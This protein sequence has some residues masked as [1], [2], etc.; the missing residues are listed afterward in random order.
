M[1]RLISRIA[2]FA[3]GAASLAPSACSPTSMQSQNPSRDSERET[4]AEESSLPRGEVKAF[5]TAEGFGA[6]T[7]GGRGGRICEVTNL[8]NSGSGSLRACA[9]ASG[10]RI[11]VFRTAGTITVR[12]DITIENPYLTVAGQTASGAGITLKSSAAHID[13][14]IAVKAH[15]VVIRHVRFRP[16]PSRRLSSMRRGIS[17]EAGAYN[18]ILDHVSVS[19]ATDENVT[20]IDGVHDVT[21]QWSIISEGLNNSTHVEGAHSMGMLISYQQFD[22]SMK[23]QDITVHHNL[24]AHNHDRNPR[25]ASWG[26]VDAVNNVVYDFGIRG[27]NVSDSSGVKVPQNVVANYFKAGPSTESYAYDV[28][29]SNDSVGAALYVEGNLG[30]HRINNNQPQSYIVDPA[31]RRYVVTTRHSAPEVATTSAS[32]A[33]DDVLAG[34]GTRVPVLDPVDRRIINDV[35][36]RTGRIIDDPS[37][38]G[39]WPILAAGT[40]LGDRDHDGMPDRWEVLHGLDPDN[41]LD[42]PAIAANGYTNVENYL[43]E[44]AGDF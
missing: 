28:Q 13:G 18:V 5:P 37:D 15:D 20:L 3:L 2:V 23:T 4:P 25:N 8:N 10:P 16:G 26:L 7:R 44:L 12:D 31:D 42:G 24:F 33:Y 39:G 41:R 21:V 30:P 43:N 14:P 32:R 17:L 29:V 19:W 34:A 1:K 38:V 40:S 6:S 22:S 27:V 36:N 35:K 9:E 11:V